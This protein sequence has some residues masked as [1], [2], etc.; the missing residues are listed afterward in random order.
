MVNNN[1]LL[2]E[3]K[4]EQFEVDE[5]WTFVKKKPKKVESGSSF[6]TA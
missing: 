1:I 5:M 3:I 6:L 4:L 2:Q